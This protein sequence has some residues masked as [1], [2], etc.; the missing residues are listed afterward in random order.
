[1]PYSAVIMAHRAMAELDAEEERTPT[2]M[3][4]NGP[5]TRCGVIPVTDPDT[6]AE[7]DMV[8]HHGAQGNG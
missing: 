2:A 5:S 7:P 3:F 4:C 8:S 6:I 1:M